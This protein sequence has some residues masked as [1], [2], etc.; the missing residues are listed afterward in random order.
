MSA[1]HRSKC[2]IYCVCCVVRVARA[3]RVAIVM[4]RACD[5]RAAQI[6]RALAMSYRA[7]HLNPKRTKPEILKNVWDSIHFFIF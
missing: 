1:N 2:C 5:A 6:W 4:R 3:S 7:T